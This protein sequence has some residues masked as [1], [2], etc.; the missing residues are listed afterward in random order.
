MDHSVLLG[1]LW[2]ACAVRYHLPLSAASL[3]FAQVSVSCISSGTTT[4]TGNNDGLTQAAC[5]RHIPQKCLVQKL[6]F[7]YWSF[8]YIKRI[9]ETLFLH[10]CEQLVPAPDI[11]DKKQ[12]SG[13]SDAVCIS[14]LQV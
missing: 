2:P 1:V 8:H 11:S 14:S 3:L 9:L 4:L 6:A 10:R 12:L 5:C 7:G 13:T